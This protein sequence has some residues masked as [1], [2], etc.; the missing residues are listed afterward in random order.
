M[1]NLDGRSRFTMQMFDDI[2]MES[3]FIVITK[4]K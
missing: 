4:T 2:L 3:E 1:N